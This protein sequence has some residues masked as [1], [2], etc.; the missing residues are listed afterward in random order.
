MRARFYL[1]RKKFEG[2]TKKQALCDKLWQRRV[3]TILV[4]SGVT[5]IL[6][7]RS[8]GTRFQPID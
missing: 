4:I 6:I 5:D 3:Q 2:V 1:N 8:G 7:S